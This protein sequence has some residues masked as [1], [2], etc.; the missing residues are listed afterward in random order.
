MIEKSAGETMPWEAAFLPGLK[1]NPFGTIVFKDMEIKEEALLGERGRG[2]AI[3]EKTEKL[4]YSYIAAAAIGTARCAFLKAQAYAQE[5]F[6]Y[7]KIIIHHQEIQRMLGAMVMKLSI[8]TAAYTR[9]FEQ[10][11]LRLP[12]SFPDA[13]LAKVYCTDSALEI[14][15]DAIQVHGGYGYMHEYGVEKIMRDSKVLQLIGG[16][17][18]SVLIST[19]AGNI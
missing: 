3:L 2:T 1:V 18:P 6:Q 10:D 12:A 8:G 11:G 13:G 7:G 5:R 16:S 4:F 19:V 17:S 9:V 14:A 15:I